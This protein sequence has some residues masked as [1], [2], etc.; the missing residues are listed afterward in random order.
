[1]VSFKDLVSKS[2]FLILKNM[3]LF[4]I[5]SDRQIIALAIKAFKIRNE[6]RNYLKKNPKTKNHRTTHPGLRLEASVC[7]ASL[8]SFTTNTRG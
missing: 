8:S 3:R 1:M 6:R 7:S 5:R 4:D 2:G